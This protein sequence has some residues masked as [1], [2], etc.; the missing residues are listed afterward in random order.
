MAEQP[1]GGKGSSRFE[2]FGKKVDEQFS[3]AIPRVEEELKKLIAHLND[4]VVPQ[5]RQVLPRHC[6]PPRSDCAD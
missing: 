2:N 5:L 3:R 1:T 6:A 4:E